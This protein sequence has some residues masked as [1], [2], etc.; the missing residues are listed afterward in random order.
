MENKDLSARPVIEL[1]DARK[2][3]RM[4]DEDVRALDGVSLK[5]NSGEFIA[6]LGPSGSGKSTMMH[7]MGFMDTLSSGTMI[8]EGTDVSHIGAS[9]RAW[10]RAHRIGFIFQAFNLLPRLTVLEN[11]MLPLTYARTARREAERRAREALERV[12]LSHRVDHLPSQLSGGER[13]RVATARAIVN[14]PGI[15]LADEPTGNLDSKNVKRTLDLLCSLRD[16]GLPVLM[17]THDLEVAKFADRVVEMRDGQVLRDYRQQS[18][19]HF[20]GTG[21]LGDLKNV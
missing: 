4:G 16:S 11:V 21:N 9:R 2:I 10:Y 1:I 20:T 12:A 8:F 13:Q 14:S 7:M 6:I 5:I 3:Y 19:R 18:C 15:L 17:V